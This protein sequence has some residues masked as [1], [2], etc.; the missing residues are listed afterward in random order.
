MAVRDILACSKAAQAVVSACMSA[1]PL[2]RTLKTEAA[3]HCAASVR[4]DA[5]ILP[6]GQGRLPTLAVRL[7]HLNE[8]TC[9]CVA[10]AA[11]LT[12]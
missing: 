9:C 8:L 11:S 10:D 3:L 2:H 1:L 7:L 12:A 4:E 6:L 5:C